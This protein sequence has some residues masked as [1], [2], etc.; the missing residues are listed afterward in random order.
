MSADPTKMHEKLGY[1]IFNDMGIASPRTAYAKLYVN[2]T[3]WGLFGVAE[4]IDGRFTKSRYPKTGDGNLYKDIWPGTQADDASVFDALVTNND[5]A[6]SPDIGDF[7]AFRDTV[8]ASGTTLNNFLEKITPFVDI[9]Y[10]VRYIA[11]DRGIM[12]FDGIMSNYGGSIRHNYCW[13]H[14]EESGLFKLIPWD[15]DKVFLYPEPN[16]WTNNKP[17]GNNKVPNWNVVNSTYTDF[18]CSF[19]PGSGG[20]TYDVEP[21]DKDK[22]LRLFRTATWNDFGSQG[23]VL[24][25]SFLIETRLN[26]RIGKWRTLIARAVGED[27]TIDSTE[28]TVMVDSLSHTIPLLRKNLEM[29]IDTLISK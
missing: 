21:I 18:A 29:M 9:P 7:K 10:L 15:L 19:D 27:P 1:S 13:Y 8:M 24:L 28:W 4:E 6:D 17:N 20:G 25:D 26:A 2:D 23:R 16:F 22:F 5:P 11:A 3:L 14:D 12:N